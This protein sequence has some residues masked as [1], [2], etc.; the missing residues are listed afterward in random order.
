VER[1][2]LARRGFGRGAEAYEKGRPDYPA[3]GV[4]WLVESLNLR[5][6]STVLDLGA[7]T[8]KFTRA[9]MARGLNLVAVEPSADMRRVLAEVLPQ[10]QVLPGTA[11]AIPLPDESVDAVAVA[12]AFHWFDAAVALRE[13]ARVVRPHG[14]I[15]LIWNERDESVPWVFELSR[16]MRWHECRPYDVG[17]DFRPVV[18]GTGLFA[19]C[20]RHRFVFTE[21]LDHDQLLDRVATSSY[22]VA[23]SDH[24]R[25]GLLADVGQWIAT[26]SNPVQLPYVTNAY[27]ARRS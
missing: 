3:D 18:D 6:G 22:I 17:M 13:M 11:D 23:M 1:D 14:G 16:R 4:D 25:A 2:E 9:L 5:R 7:G 20:E 24:D 15:G 12:Q 19:P 10:V 26:L 27:V 21:A 8:G